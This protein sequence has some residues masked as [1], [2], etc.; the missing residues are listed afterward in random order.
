MENELKIGQR[1]IHYKTNFIYEIKSFI[2]IQEF[3]SW[4]PAV[5]YSS[6]DIPDV[7]YVRTVSEFSEK[8]TE[9]QNDSK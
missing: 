1:Y 9:V 3:N 6:V 7:T 2:N 4:I 5:I 8:F